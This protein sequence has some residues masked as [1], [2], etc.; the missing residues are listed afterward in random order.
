[1]LS[2]ACSAGLSMKE[3]LKKNVSILRFIN[4]INF[5]RQELIYKWKTR[6][7]TKED[8]LMYLLLLETKYKINNTIN[9]FKRNFISNLCEHCAICLKA[10][11]KCH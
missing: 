11:I 6:E 10:M 2:W 1:M 9:C 5:K 3:V 4:K 8:G 7:P